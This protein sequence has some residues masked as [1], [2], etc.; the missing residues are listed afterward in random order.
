MF[1][2]QTGVKYDMPVVFGPSLLPD[3][4]TFGEVGMVSISYV[5]TPDAA[6]ALVP[7]HFRLP[8][9]PI[10]TYSRMTYRDVDYLGGRGYHELTV[11]I[12]AA[13]DTDAGEVRGSY[14]P[15]VWIDDAAALVAGREYMGY[16][17]I[18]G[19]LPPVESAGD[20]RSFVVRE[21]GAPLLR[22]EVTGVALLDDAR[23]D[24]ARQAAAT[25]TVLGWKYIAGPGG[26]VDAD[27]PTAISL[28]FWWSHAWT[29]EGCIEFDAPSVEAAPFSSRIVAALAALPVVRYRGAF[30]ADG[31]GTIDRAATTR[32]HPRT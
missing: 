9:E 5:T 29:G 14:M 4:T 21:Y 28:S 16:A 10:V 3:H 22:G 30:V 1:M 25:T 19:E 32:L 18:A 27:Y 17:K 12:S 2:P 23:L 26:I 15:V 6:A 7:H 24:R 20:S 13:C 11:G 8:T 31:R